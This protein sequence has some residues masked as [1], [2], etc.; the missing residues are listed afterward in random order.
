MQQLSDQQSSALANC[1]KSSRTRKTKTARN[2]LPSASRESVRFVAPKLVTNGR[3]C[4]NC[5]VFEPKLFGD[6]K[7][8]RTNKTRHRNAAAATA[9]HRD[10]QRQHDSSGCFFLRGVHVGSKIRSLG[11]SFPRLVVCFFFPLS[12]SF[13]GK[14]LFLRFFDNIYTFVFKKLH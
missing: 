13:S 1:P 11:H 12:F 7:G 3:I 5:E 6:Q 4:T 2:I 10:P 14:M 8:G 9:G